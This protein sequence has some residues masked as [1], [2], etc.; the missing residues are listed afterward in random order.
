MGR[1]A[2]SAASVIEV[3]LLFAAAGTVC[4]VKQEVVVRKPFSGAPTQG[5]IAQAA[6]GWLW[7]LPTC[8]IQAGS[9]SSTGCIRGRAAGGSGSPVQGQVNPRRT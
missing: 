2:P 9:R 1:P 5:E 7:S 6:A 8:E 3:N 4:E